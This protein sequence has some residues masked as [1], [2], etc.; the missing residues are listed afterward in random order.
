MSRVWAF[1][2]VAGSLV[3]GGWAGVSGATAAQVGG[4]DAPTATKKTKLSGDLVMECTYYP[5]MMVR[6][7]PREESDSETLV[8]KSANAPCKP[9][10]VAGATSLPATR[11]LLGRKGSLLIFGDDG[12]V[13]VFDLKTGKTIHEGEVFRDG[14]GG[15]STDPKA[16]VVTG[17]ADGLRL[18]YRHEVYETCSLVKDRACWGKLTAKKLVPAELAKTPPDCTAAYKLPHAAPE[19]TSAVGFRRDVKITA[20]GQVSTAVSGPVVCRSL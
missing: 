2:A 4:L 11:G 9:G 16:L 3:A 8:I 10:K 12:G 6:I 1:V 15:I 14:D 19:N 5:D 7:E 17:E 18:A 13:Q 20:A